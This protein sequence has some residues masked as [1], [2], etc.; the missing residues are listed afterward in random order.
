MCEM[1]KVA[2]SIINEYLDTAWSR[3]D[4]RGQDGGPHVG[5]QRLGVLKPH[6]FSMFAYFICETTERMSVN[7]ACSMSCVI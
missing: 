4:P 5:R 3:P 6:A 1:C 7:V 2:V